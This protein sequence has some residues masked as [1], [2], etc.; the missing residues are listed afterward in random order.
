MNK[1]FAILFVSIISFSYAQNKSDDYE[2]IRFKNFTEYSLTVKFNSINKESFQIG[3][4]VSDSVEFTINSKSTSNEYF[5]K[6]GELIV[7]VIYLEPIP[8]GSNEVK[9]AQK[10]HEQKIIVLVG[11]KTKTLVINGGIKY[12]FK[13][14]VKSTPKVYSY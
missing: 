1:L 2:T 10:K 12:G 13:I 11:K 7:N 9:P 4:F 3:K 14:E 5:V 6:Q 8:K